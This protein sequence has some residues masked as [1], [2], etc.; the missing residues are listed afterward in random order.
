MKL[1]YQTYLKFKKRNLDI[2]PNLTKRNLDIKFVLTE[3]NLTKRNLDI[4]RIL[5]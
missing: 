2:K 5:A 4:K 1:G 3:P